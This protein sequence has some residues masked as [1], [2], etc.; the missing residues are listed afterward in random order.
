MCDVNDVIVD[1][2]DVNNAITY[3]TEVVEVKFDYDAEQSD[4]LTL[5]VGDIIKSCKLVEDGW[6]EGELNGKRGIFPDNFVVKKEI[7]PPPPGLQCVL[8][9]SICVYVHCVC[10][11]V[12]VCTH[13]RT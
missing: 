13:A 3:I 7:T 12:C 2:Y 8:D 6:M 11:Y 9:L 10:A 1:K 4:E 5:R